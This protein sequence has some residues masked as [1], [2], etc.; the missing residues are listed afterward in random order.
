MRGR[1]LVERS[2]PDMARQRSR[3]DFFKVAGLVA[4]GAVATG[5]GAGLAWAD[6]KTPAGLVI[7]QA[8]AA[9]P[10]DQVPA[11]LARIIPPTFPAKD[12]RV[13]DYGAKND[14][15][16]DCTAAFKKAVAACNAAGGGRVVVP[17]GTY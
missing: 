16:T 6:E 12:F 2:T 4:G 15:K 14:G 11:I 1:R 7:P 13:T 10:W 8:V 9:D 5:V 3:R 17:S